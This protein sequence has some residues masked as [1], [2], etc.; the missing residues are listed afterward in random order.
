LHTVSI[1]HTVAKNFFVS[2]KRTVQWERFHQLKI[3]NNAVHEGKKPHKFSIC[4]YSFTTEGHIDTIHE[5]FNN[6]G[7]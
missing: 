2:I 7:I 6:Y 1:K 4:D 5:G 3:H